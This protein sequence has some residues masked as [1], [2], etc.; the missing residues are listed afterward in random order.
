MT[1]NAEIDKKIQ[2]LR[3]VFL[4]GD[5]QA[6]AQIA[7]WEEK[8]KRLLQ[9]KDYAE[10]PVT[11][12]IVGYLRDRVKGIDALLAT[13]RALTDLERATLFERKDA[14][15]WYLQLFDARIIEKQIEHIDSALSFELE[16]KDVPPREQEP[17][18]K[19]R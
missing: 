15:D 5:P 17:D 11:Q 16:G 10:H 1:G 18:D 9:Q 2:D 8:T 13:D 7:A 19:K 3:A 14:A 6:K 4:D 12:R